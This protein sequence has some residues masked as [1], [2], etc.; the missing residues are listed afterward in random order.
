MAKDVKIKL[1]EE[2]KAKIKEGT[3]QDLREI[4]VTNVGSNPAIAAKTARV[5]ARETARV[6]ARETARVN[7]R[8]T[9]R[10][11]AR[12]TARVNARETARVNAKRS[13]KVNV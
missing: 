3:G 7:A 4:R 11:N 10:V 2:Q 1:T 13:A 6:N 12:E 8:E 9:A 5:N